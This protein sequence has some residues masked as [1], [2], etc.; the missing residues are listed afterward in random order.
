MCDIVSE[1]VSSDALYKVTI[2]RR[3]DGLYEVE[4]FRWTREIIP[5]HSEVSAYWEPVSR[6]SLTDTLPNAEKLADVELAAWS[7]EKS[8]TT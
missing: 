8:E 7:G 4:A 2:L 1:I 5:H 6:P 3:K